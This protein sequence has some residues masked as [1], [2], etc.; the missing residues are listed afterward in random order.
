MIFTLFQRRYN[1]M[2]PL[3][4]DTDSVLS[5]TVARGSYLTEGTKTCG[6][7]VVSQSTQRDVPTCK[8][9][10]PGS[11]P[12]T[13][14]SKSLFILCQDDHEDILNISD[15]LMPIKKSI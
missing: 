8:T 1:V 13:V 3:G 4:P 9:H 6:F 12:E 5:N 11:K 2:C 15:S 14:Q 7:H 10:T